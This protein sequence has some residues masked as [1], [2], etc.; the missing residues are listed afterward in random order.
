MR[1]LVRTCQAAPAKAIA[2]GIGLGVGIA[3]EFVSA[4]SARRFANR[5]AALPEFCQHGSDSTTALPV[6]VVRFSGTTGL[7]YGGIAK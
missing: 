6:R 4:I 5:I 3:V 7:N 2:V 1:A